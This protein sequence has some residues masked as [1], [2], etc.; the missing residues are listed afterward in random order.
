MAHYVNSEVKVLLQQIREKA[1]HITLDRFTYAFI[2][3]AKDFLRNVWPKYLLIKLNIYLIIFV[4]CK[5]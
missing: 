1:Q 5:I 3:S 2:T 4:Y